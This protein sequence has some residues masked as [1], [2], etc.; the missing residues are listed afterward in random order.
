M[1]ASHFLHAR[2]TSAFYG[3]QASVCRRQ[4]GLGKLQAVGM[5][6]QHPLL[7]GAWQ[8][9]RD[10]A[11]REGLLKVMVSSGWSYCTSRCQL[12]F[13]SSRGLRKH[14]HCRKANAMVAAFHPRMLDLMKFYQQTSFLW[15]LQARASSFARRW[16]AG[17]LG[18]AFQK[19]AAEAGYSRAKACMQRTAIGHWQNA[20]LAMVSGFKKAR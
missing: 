12:S 2:L 3:W 13:G 15:R 14:L 1:A 9:W 10:F 18:R 16:M 17:Y 11:R 4:E 20:R 19:W 7:M 6:L 8:A 5:R